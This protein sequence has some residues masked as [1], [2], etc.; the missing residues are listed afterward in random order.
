MFHKLLKKPSFIGILSAFFF[1]LTFV[2]NELMST[3]SGIWIWSAILRY[4]W[5]MPLLLIMS[6]LFK[7]SI[8][9]KHVIQV[10]NSNKVHWFIGSHL[11]FVLFYIPLCFANDVFPGWL[12]ASVWQITIVLGVLIAPVISTK[13]STMSRQRIP[14]SILPWLLL[15]L[16]GVALTVANYFFRSGSIAHFGVALLMMVIAAISYPVGNR[17]VMPVSFIL[18]GFERLFGMLVCTYPTWLGLSVV[19]YVRNGGPPLVKFKTHCWLVCF[20]V[21]LLPVY[22]FMQ[23]H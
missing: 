2:L 4:L 22:F 6:V 14:L 3:S 11:C 18:N 1:S 20:L 17:I 10:I 5:M 21:L 12:T 13:N 9:I 7:G 15:I 8:A 16:I 19:V 23:L